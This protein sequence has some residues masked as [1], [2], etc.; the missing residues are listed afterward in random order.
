MTTD[1]Y[2]ADCQ[3]EQERRTALDDNR[4]FWAADEVPLVVT[5]PRQPVC[6]QCE[7]WQFGRQ[8]HLADGTTQYSQGFC[9]LRAAADLQQMSPT[10]APTCRFYEEAIPF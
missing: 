8:L 6:A 3:Y 7:N 10:Y 5:P 1:Q 9:T 4:A 2:S